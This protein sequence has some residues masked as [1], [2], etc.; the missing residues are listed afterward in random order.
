MDA[1][2]NEFL[3]ALPALD[4]ANDA[5]PLAIS[6][7]PVPAGSIKR[8]W[9]LGT[10]QAQIAAAY[11][12][13]W[14]RGLF[15]DAELHR[16]DAHVAAA[17]RMLG[18]M[19]YLRGA[20]MKVGQ[21]LAAYP[22]VAPDAFIQT[23]G[24]LHFDA[25]PMHFALVREQLENELGADVHDVFAEFDERAFA[26]ASLGQV[27]RARLRSGER[28]AVKIQYPGI[29]ATIRAD[30]RSAAALI[31]PL[32]LS[33]KWDNIAAQFDEVRQAL[34]REVDYRAEARMTELART[35]FTPEDGIVVPRVIDEL[36]SERVLV[37]ELLDGQHVDD[38]LAS[39]PSQEAR[40]AIGRRIYLAAF[41]LYYQRMNYADP[42]PGNYLM[43]D[44]GRLGL[45]DFGCVRTFDDDDV[46]LLAETELAF[47]NGRDA[48]RAM[49]VRFCGLTP[50]QARD[51]ERMAIYEEWY[52]WTTEPL[53]HDTFDFSDPTHLRL[54]I[55]I[56][57]RT[58]RGRYTESHPLQVY[59]GRAILG[60]RAMMY[61]LGA[62]VDV[63]ALHDA[64]WAASNWRT[65]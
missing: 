24:R 10:M 61:R 62:R 32:R 55:S 42:H 56:L 28:V 23:L 15:G 20:I 48:L 59:I 63:R 41:R 17:V 40:D 34:E 30:L 8:L 25:P 36:S 22:D 27:H 14:M 2:L 6:T 12:A 53:L 52:R 11:L 1:K 64:E 9:T 65:Q 39:H 33:A 49:M 3:S 54:G 60:V 37:T 19:T 44:D 18:A 38:F 51:E 5:P 43:L 45:I 16:A 50:E 31:A 58:A 4:D 26:A 47:T 46:A 21:L 35:Q 13:A 7:L 29:A 57:S